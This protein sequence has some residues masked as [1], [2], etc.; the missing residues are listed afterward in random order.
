MFAELVDDHC[1]SLPG[2]AP[3]QPFGPDTLV[4]TVG[5]RM[6]AIRTV[7][8]TGVSVACATPQEAQRAVRDGKAMSAPYLRGQGWA[9]FP[10][11]TSSPEELRVRILDSYDRVV[12][13][14]PDELRIALS[15]RGDAVAQ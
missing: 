8:G 7:N 1:S 2:A 12:G 15:G 14:L 11:H 9:L 10:Y 6:F 4:W 3:E 5:G 13:G